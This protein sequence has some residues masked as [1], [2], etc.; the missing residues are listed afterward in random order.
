VAR[1]ALPAGEGRLAAELAKLRAKLAKEGLFDPARKRPLPPFPR[2]V[3]V[4][5]SVSGAA[6]HDIVEVARGRCPVRLVVAHCQVQGAEAPESI[7]RALAL[8]Q[9]LPELDVVIVGRGGG[10]AE[11]LA[12]FD[13]E[14][15]ARAIAA[16]RV[17][18]V[19][20]VGH[21]VDVSIADLVADVRAATPSNAAELVVP[22]RALLEGR[23]E[24]LVRRIERALD[25]RLDRER[26]R[27][28]RLVRRLGD[29]RRTFGRTRATLLDLERALHAALRRRLGRERARLSAL[30]A[31]VAR[32]DP[33]TRLG[34]ARRRLAGLERRLGAVR[35]TLVARRRADLGELAARM[36]ALSPLAVLA[37][38]YAIALHGPTGRALVRAADARP[39]DAVRLRL[40]EGALDA[41]VVAVTPRGGA[42]DADGG[43]GGAG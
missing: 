6:V 31:R 22:D 33:R 5:T 27:L 43:T 36:Q 9:R 37:R 11:D 24:T 25:A 38:G 28:D 29:P 18:V 34:D 21:E 2:T 40:H 13:D 3:G 20:A 14:R 10:G 42:P 1:L 19:S 23:L 7:V 26:L 41:T 30:G 39:G 16:C 15:V 32:H 8:V 4:V 12:A 35:A 17:P